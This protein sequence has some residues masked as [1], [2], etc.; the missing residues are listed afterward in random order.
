MI[1]CCPKD[2]GKGRHR[3]ALRSA[4]IS[5]V[6]RYQNA[7]SVNPVLCIHLLIPVNSTTIVLGQYER[8]QWIL[9]M[10]L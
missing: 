4:S 6:I 2:K 8:W 3:M 10:T 9:L 5:C 1:S 7:S